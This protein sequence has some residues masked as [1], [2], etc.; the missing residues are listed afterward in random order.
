MVWSKLGPGAWAVGI[1]E[2]GAPVHGDGIA[3]DAVR[4]VQAA[5]LEMVTMRPCLLLHP[6]RTADDRNAP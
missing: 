5:R 2:Y 4:L 1:R 3:L 6:A